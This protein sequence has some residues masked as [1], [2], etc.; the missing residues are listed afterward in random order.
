V[1]QYFVLF[2][3]LSMHLNKKVLMVMVKIKNIIPYVFVFFTFFLT[4]SKLSA[5]IFPYDSE[6]IEENYKKE[7]EAFRL[8]EEKSFRN[9]ET[10]L[11]S[12]DYFARF[13]GLNFFPVDLKYRIVGKLTR[14]SES[15]KMN[16]EM[17][18][19]TPYGFMHYGK[20]NFYLEGELVELQ[21]FE[22]PSRNATTAIFVPF[23][24]L[25]TGKE[26]FGGGRF[27]IIK[28][29]KGDQI[30]VDFNLSINPICV[31]DPEHSC[32]IPPETNYI[33]KRITAGVKMYY[34]PEAENSQ[35]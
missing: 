5:Q 7:I 12:E 25:T 8:K 30:V 15:E 31:Y 4:N 9:K 3:Y 28:I 20:I 2:L 10:T 17:T 26:N 24:D 14:L 35:N 18:F 6:L 11:L 27:M 29:P 32:P 16:L 33:T 13:T 1:K 23:T 19:G 34:D 22:F 21:V